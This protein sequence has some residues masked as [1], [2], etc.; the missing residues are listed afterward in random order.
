VEEN[1]LSL[2]PGSGSGLGLGLGLGWNCSEPRRL[3]FGCNEDW[4]WVLVRASLLQV[5]HQI[6]EALLCKYSTL[7]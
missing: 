4:V 5:L 2:I 3:F 7:P 6:Q 1:S